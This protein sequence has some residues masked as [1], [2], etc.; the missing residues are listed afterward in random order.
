[1]TT[2]QSLP[3]SARMIAEDEAH[4]IRRALDNVVGWTSEIIAATDNNPTNGKGEIAGFASANHP[5]KENE[6]CFHERAR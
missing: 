3:I 4:R 5:A 6:T 1:M 2:V